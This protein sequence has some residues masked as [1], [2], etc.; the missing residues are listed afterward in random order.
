MRIVIVGAGYVG[1][2][3]GA[4]FAQF[5]HHVTCVDTD[6]EKIAKIMEGE[7]PIYEPGL[8]ELVMRNMREKRLFFLTQM[9]DAVPHADAVF[10]AVGTP[11]SRRGDGYADLSYVYA[12]AQDIAKHLQGYTVVIDKST[13]PIGTA[14]Q[15]KRIIAEIAPNA[16][17]DVASNP[18]FL[19]EGA[20]I[21]DFMHPDR[22]VIGV[23]A[24][25]AEECIRAIYKPINL[26]E[27]PLLV[28]DIATAEMIKYAANAFLAIKI[29]YINEIARL[30]E[31]VGAN[32]VDVAK[33]IGMDGRIGRKFLH[34]GPGYGGSCFPKDTKALS[35][36]AEEHGVPL[37]IVTAAIEANNAQKAL[38]IKKIRDAFDGCESGKIIAVLGLAFKPETDDM[39]DAPALTII[40]ALVERGAKVHVH[41]PQAMQEARKYLPQSVQYFS[42]PYDACC[43]AHA[44][45]IMTEWNQYRA[46]A[47]ERLHACMNL[48]RFFIDL[49]NVYVPA[50]VRSY[51][52]QYIGVGRS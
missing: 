51:G 48:P 43:G 24:E 5:G 26:T 15:V 52:L 20:A 1:L 2:V 30:C 22:I 33:G 8:D 46:L 27:T 11:T 44:V 25:Q 42:D 17:F 37:R 21:K 32:V 6:A 41:D 18:E 49:R 13:V 40:P 19:R 3:T 35:A 28:V 38:M 23:D 29:S 47:L 36:I 10:I 31:S 39:R 50:D 14:T 45:V 4:C 7:M 9:G 16:Y 12:A 34:P